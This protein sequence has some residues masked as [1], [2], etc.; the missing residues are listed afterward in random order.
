MFSLYQYQQIKMLSNFVL[1][2]IIVFS[3]FFLFQPSFN[4]YVS[5]YNV[6]KANLYNRI[7]WS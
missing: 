3:Y 6:N 1:D 7:N 5:N 2:K 4:L